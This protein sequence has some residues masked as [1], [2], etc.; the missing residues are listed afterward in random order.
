[1]R[2]E[3]AAAAIAAPE[4]GRWLRLRYREQA[5]GRITHSAE[6]VMLVL[7]LLVVPAVVL[8]ASSSHALHAASFVLDLLIWI[9]FALELGFILAVT[10]DR[11]RALRAHWLDAC[12]VVI[13]IPIAPPLLQS[14]RALRLLRL[15]RLTRLGLFGARAFQAGHRLLQPGSF[16]YLAASVG[17]LVV[18]AGAVISTVD[19]KDVPTAWDGIW[20]AVVTVTT[21]GYGDFYPTTTAGRAIGI[22]LMIVGV[23]FF[24]MLTAAIAATFVRSDSENRDPEL[25]EILQRLSRI[26][27][28]LQERTP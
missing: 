24:A 10:S 4:E 2:A 7:A 28:A 19:S 15:L 13:S 25:A 23:S 22:L 27:D 8:E 9:G 5:D 3:E 26:E 14:G 21:V 6:W 16:R 1:V 18:V 20:W 11:G 17:L 12:I